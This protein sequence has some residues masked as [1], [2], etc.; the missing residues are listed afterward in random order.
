MVLKSVRMED[1]LSPSTLEKLIDNGHSSVGPAVATEATQPQCAGNEQEG[2]V[3]AADKIDLK[4]PICTTP[5]DFKSFEKW[6]ST[7]Q[8][9]TVVET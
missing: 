8:F 9:K 4:S 3:Q 1:K 6:A 7:P 2:N 5:E